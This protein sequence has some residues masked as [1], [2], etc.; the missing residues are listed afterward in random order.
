MLAHFFGERTLRPRTKAVP[1][2]L[3]WVDQWAYLP[4]AAGSEANSTMLRWAPVYVPAGC[5]R[6]VDACHVHVNYHG[7]TPNPKNGLTASWWERLLWVHNIQLN[8]YAEANSVVVVYPQAAGSHD[9]GEGCFNWASYEDGTRARARRRHIML[10]YSLAEPPRARMCASMAL[11]TFVRA[12]PQIRSS[13][14]DS[15]FS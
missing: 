2:H 4:A 8:E 11:V 5:S 3:R 6:S 1:R 13:T 15:A 9:I 7:C 14:H 10:W 12:L